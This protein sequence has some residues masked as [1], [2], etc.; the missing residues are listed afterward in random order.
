MQNYLQLNI[1]A[2]TQLTG[3]VWY[4]RVWSVGVP[5]DANTNHYPAMG[6]VI[7]C[8]LL[9]FLPFVICHLLFSLQ[10][11]PEVKVLDILPYNLQVGNFV[12]TS[13]GHPQPNHHVQYMPSELS[14]SINA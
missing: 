1:D 5:V 8:I 2:H 7:S 12:L 6:K 10:T 4:M 11:L 13:T 9:F 3:H 14:V